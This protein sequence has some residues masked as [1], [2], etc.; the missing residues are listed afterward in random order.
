[1][2]TGNTLKGEVFL[3]TRQLETLSVQRHGTW[4]HDP[5]PLGGR[6]KRGIIRII[7]VVTL[8]IMDI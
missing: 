1:M 4:R 3:F 6:G 5:P 7:T 8:E 2:V